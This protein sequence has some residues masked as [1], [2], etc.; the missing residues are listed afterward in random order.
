[1]YG[2]T[3]LNDPARL[4]LLSE[5]GLADIRADEVFDAISTLAAR[6]LDSPTGL[7]SIVDNERQHFAGATGLTGELAA[8]R[9]TPLSHSYCRHVVEGGVPLVV[10]DART[11]PMTRDNPAIS[12]Y[13]AIAY[14]GFPIVSVRGHTVGSVCAVDS[15]P[16]EWSAQ[17]IGTLKELAR[18]AGMIIDA[19]LALAAAESPMPH[20][21]RF[22][23]VESGAMAKEFLRALFD[24]DTTGVVVLDRDGG[25]M[26]GNDAFDRIVGR[27][28]MDLIGV[29]FT[30]L[31]HPEDRERSR[32][33]FARLLAGDGSAYPHDERCQLP[34]G[35]IAWGRVTAS[36][37]HDARGAAAYALL[38]K[39]DITVELAAMADRRVSDAALARADRLRALGELAT[40]VAHDFNNALTVITACTGMVLSQLPQDADV[41]VDLHDIE[42]A[43]RKAA[44]LS[45][46]LLQFARGQVGHREPI[47]LGAVIA[48][49][50]GALFKS[51]G[52][53]IA[54]ETKVDSAAPL[55][56]ADKVA[57]QQIL[58]NLV[59]NARD[60][61]SGTGRI[62]VSVQRDGDRVVLAV[63]DTGAG[64]P[65]AVRERIFEP[66]FT[67]KG[68]GKG[69]GLGLATVQRIM[70][71]LG[72]EIA[73]ASE[74]GH[75]TTIRLRFPA[76]RAA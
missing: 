9:F 50:Q 51:V 39:Q 38:L 6:L 57:L 8:S 32:E 58:L 18:L 55:I 69:T 70:N 13:D 65:H 2:I 28:T 56:L 60:A 42:I 75:G 3:A 21:R 11:H 16:R 47:N 23:E 20:A 41:R 52:A 63:T 22:P 37:I 53:G 5:A 34:D 15:Q 46:Q 1:M 7:V 31:V 36:V 4:K 62:T 12:D 44:G 59:I 54:I 61:M 43:A 26:R 14:A 19:R 45:Q 33:A 64:M 73:V 49:M 30:E 29:H 71:E 72:G 40:G 17:D 48:E 35:S 27:D 74:V 10:G 66:F 68:E 67:T 76:A 25:I 24:N